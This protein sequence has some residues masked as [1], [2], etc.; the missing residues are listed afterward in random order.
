MTTKSRASRGWIAL[1]M[2]LVLAAAGGAALGS[3]GRDDV[4]AD[5]GLVGGRCASDRD[6]ARRCVIDEDLPGGYC[7]LSCLTDRE[8]PRGT[9]CVEESGGIC[10]LSCMDNQHC[11]DLGLPYLCKAKGRREN[12]DSKVLVCIAD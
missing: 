1:A 10:M 3:C 4:G 5:G 12:K 7:S 9:F 8:C 11:A 2:A 6:C